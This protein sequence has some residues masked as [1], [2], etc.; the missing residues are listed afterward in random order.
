MTEVAQTLEALAEEFG[1]NWSEEFELSEP[2]PSAGP[3][4]VPPPQTATIQLSSETMGG[5]RTNTL[6]TLE[7]FI[8]GCAAVDGFFDLHEEHAVF[9]K[10]GELG[11]SLEDVTSIIDERCRIL[12][13]TRHSALTEQLKQML[14]ALVQKDG[15]IDHRE[16]ERLIRH[17]VGR[18]MPRRQ[19]EEHCLTLMLDHGWPAKEPFW[20]RWFTRRCR[21][22]GLE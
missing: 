18:K 9:R 13:W 4:A 8:D 11:L 5:L 22:L 12:G 2:L 21:R 19:A 10:G 6:E 7:R 16:F 3:G 15:E 20:N 17:A 1:A 14:Q